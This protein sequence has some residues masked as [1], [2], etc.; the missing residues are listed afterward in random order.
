MKLKVI[1]F[2]IVVNCII[3][4]ILCLAAMECIEQYKTQQNTMFEEIR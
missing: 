4:A 1:V 2:I 3:A